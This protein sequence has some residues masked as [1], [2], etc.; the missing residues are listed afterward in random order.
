MTRKTSFYLLIS[1]FAFLI[2]LSCSAPVLAQDGTPPPVNVAL[3]ANPLQSDPGWG[4]GARPWD[5]TDGIAFYRDTWAHGLAFTGG[6]DNWAG[7]P[8]GYRQA[9][10]DF[11]TARQ[12]NRVLVWH[13]GDQ[14]IP[15]TYGVD[16]WDGSTWLPAGGTS[17]VRRD[18]ATSGG[19]LPGWGAVPT[20]TIFPTVTGSKVRFWLN[21]C[22]IEHGWIYEFQV[23]AEA[24]PSVNI[25]LGA[26]TRQSDPGW[27]GGALP[28]DM[29]DDLNAYTDT[30]AH[31]LAF[32]GGDDQ[33]AGQPCGYRQATLDF[34]TARQFNRVLV[35]HHGDNHMPSTYGID[36]WSGSDWLSVGGSSAQRWDLRSGLGS[37]W[38]SVPTETIFPAVTGSKVR[39]WLN[40]CDI[41]HGWIYEFQVFD[42]PL[43]SITGHVTD[44]RNHPLAGVTVAA[45][46]GPSAITDATGAYAITGL[47]AGSYTLT[48]ARKGYSFSPSGL[49]VSL[50]PNA[51]S[52]DFVGSTKV[53]LPLMV[54]NLD[55]QP[56]TP[57]PTHTPTNT[58]TPTATPTATATPSQTPTSTSTPTST[59]THTPTSTS[60][61]TSTPTPTR[62]PT[63]TPCTT[64][65]I[66][67][68]FVPPYG[69]S[70]NL[71]GRVDCVTP[72]EY[73]I[74]VYIYVGGGWW[75]KP[76]WTSPLTPIRADGTFTADITTGGND[77]YA[78]KI[79]AFVVPNGYNPPS[80]S[81]GAVLPSEL[82]QN[83][84][85][86]KIVDRP[87]SFKTISFAGQTWYVKTAEWSADP[88]PCYYSDR[89]EDVWVD[90]IGRLHLKIVK[91]NGRW[92]CSEV[93]TTQQYGHGTYVY[94]LASPVDQLDKNAVLGLFTWDD[95]SPAYSHREID[96]EMSRWGAASD[97]NVQY[98]VSPWNNAGHRYRFNLTLPEVQSV[99]AFTWGT[100]SV[101]FGSY[102]GNLW[103]AEP[104]AELQSWTYTGSDVPPAG[105]GNARINLWLFNR[106]VP[107]DG[108]EIEVI[109]TGFSFIP[110]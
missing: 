3:G 33:W 89:P 92:Y 105:Q 86:Y 13:Y 108:Q 31:G 4:G 18:L 109:V 50:P 74:A 16:Y 43:Y 23:F 2:L 44:A 110:G 22:N 90:V 1:V 103:P 75:T 62:T 26:A 34:G 106:A 12:F 51:T 28:G 58:A 29:V 81:G 85:A 64:P 6:D 91:R 54:R 107:S 67:F 79:A 95:T 47:T 41:E 68:T 69:S 27:G 17:S 65:S 53:F 39:F 21:N 24:S 45:A 55:G 11:G 10:L 15:T 93:F 76:Y 19:G 84:A 5:I 73:K 63:P 59:P 99:H 20:E 14:H 30:W 49:S 56:P 38:G 71:A 57:T 42:T 25:A 101:A 80:M 9:T 66:E 87:L 48:A 46:G 8:C 52:Q 102:R 83:A 40:N 7:K 78:T 104:G 32:T 98:V 70:L 96:I 37:G 100:D 97:P 60:T 61:P 88:G 82:Y 77:P 94:K 36:Y 35:W 72:A